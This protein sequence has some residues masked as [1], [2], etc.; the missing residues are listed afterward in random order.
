M[1]K[2][3]GF[4][5]KTAIHSKNGKPCL[6]R[7]EV[8]SRVQGSRTMVNVRCIQRADGWNEVHEQYERIKVY[9]RYQ[10]TTKFSK[11]FQYKTNTERNDQFGFEDVIHI[12]DLTIITTTDEK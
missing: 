9:A 2:V 4:I 10:G 11:R 12:K 5:G 1:N 7:V 8:L 3:N 6:G